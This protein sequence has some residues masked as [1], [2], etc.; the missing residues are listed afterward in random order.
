LLDCIR[1]VIEYVF[2]AGNSGSEVRIHVEGAVFYLIITLL[3]YGLTERR[4]DGNV[5]WIE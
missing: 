2:Y 4:K 1:T 5:V 3:P